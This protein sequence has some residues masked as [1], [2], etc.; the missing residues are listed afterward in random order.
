M[1]VQLNV[2]GGHAIKT[3]G[4]VPWIFLSDIPLEACLYGWAM[5]QVEA[6]RS[7]VQVVEW[8]NPDRVW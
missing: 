2:K 1:P 6:F 4:C 7:R 5:E 3:A 8:R